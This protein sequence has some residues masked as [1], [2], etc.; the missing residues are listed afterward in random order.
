MAEPVRLVMNRKGVAALLRGG[1]I[2]ADLRARAYRVSAAAGPGMFVSV[3]VGRAR[4]RASVIT[5]TDEA[6]KAEAENRAL[7]RALDAAR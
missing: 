3:R 7:T 5:A 1:E 4:V 6:R 2:A